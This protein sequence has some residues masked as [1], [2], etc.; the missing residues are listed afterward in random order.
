MGPEK[1]TGI[2][3]QQINGT[4]WDGAGIGFGVRGSNRP[5]VTILFGGQLF[6]STVN[7]KQATNSSQDIIQVYRDTLPKAPIVFSYSTNST[8]WAISRQFPISSD[9]SKTPGK[10]LVSVHG[11]SNCTFADHDR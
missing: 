3:S 8:I 6:V 2:L 7:S 11:I 1:G 9:C 4:K 10:N 5:D